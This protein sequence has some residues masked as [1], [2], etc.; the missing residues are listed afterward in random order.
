MQ[1][2][3]CGRNEW[4]QRE[5]PCGS[6]LPLRVLSIVQKRIYQRAYA[7]II[8][9][10]NIAVSCGPVAGRHIRGN[11]IGCNISIWIDATSEA[12]ELRNLHL[13]KIRAG[14][15]QHCLCNGG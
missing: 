10:H 14:E 5:E 7:R 3:T 2:D 15:V 1:S 8:R 4:K 12:D 9:D 11:R 6:P 13:G